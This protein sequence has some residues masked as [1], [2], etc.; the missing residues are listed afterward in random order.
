MDD[1]NM[2]DTK[3]YL[4]KVISEFEKAKITLDYKNYNVKEIS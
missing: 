1:V 4:R 2:K 3:E